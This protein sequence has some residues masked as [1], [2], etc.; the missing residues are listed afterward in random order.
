MPARVNHKE[1]IALFHQLAR[2][3]PHFLDVTGN[4]R[5]NLD[6]FHRLGA[7]GE[8]VPLDQFLCSTGATVTVGGGGCCW[9]GI[10]TAT[11]D[12]DG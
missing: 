7:A 6:R 1:H 8:F 10:G 5:A 4:T 9:R 12:K 3:K 2:L 11:G